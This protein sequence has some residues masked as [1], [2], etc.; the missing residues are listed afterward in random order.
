MS[1]KIRESLMVDADSLYQLVQTY[2]D[3]EPEFIDFFKK[4]GLSNRLYLNIKYGVNFNPGRRLLLETMILELGLTLD[5][6]IKRHHA[7]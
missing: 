2:R 7:R 5:K 4:E 6:T 3:R 1:K